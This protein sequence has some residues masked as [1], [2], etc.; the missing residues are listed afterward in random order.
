MCV[1]IMVSVCICLSLDTK[2]IFISWLLWI[3][4]QWTWA[5]RWPYEMAISFSLSIPKRGLLDHMVVTFNFC[6]NFIMFFTMAVGVSLSPCQHLFSLNFCLFVCNSCPNR[7]KVI[8]QSGFL[9]CI[10]LMISDVE[11]LSAHLLG[12]CMCY[13]KK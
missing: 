9:I 12:I 11:H 4:L 10:F 8:P 2:V 7:C 1:C 5:S 3:M 6:G 13:F